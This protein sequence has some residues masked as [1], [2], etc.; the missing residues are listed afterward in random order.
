MEDRSFDK[1]HTERLV[2]RRFGFGDCEVFAA[3]RSDPELA[4][5]QAWESCS[6]E[7]ARR[8]VASLREAAPGTPGSWFQFAVTLAPSG[9][10]IGDCALRCRRTDPR[11]AELGF[12][13]ATAYQGQG[14]AS[15]AVR[16]LLQ[17]AFTTLALHRVFSLTDVRNVSAQRLLERLRFRREGQLRQSTW[18]KGEWVSELL[19]AQLEAEWRASHAS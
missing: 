16:C 11:Q 10:L 12:T 5:Y 1:L 9:P 7:E 3:Y 19:Y 13:F 18:L 14:Y 8:F 2:V 4:R 17:Y 6:T 15:E